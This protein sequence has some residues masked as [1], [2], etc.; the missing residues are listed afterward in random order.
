VCDIIVKYAEQIDANNIVELLKKYEIANIEVSYIKEKIIHFPYS[1][2]IAIDNN[3]II[4]TVFLTMDTL[5]SV[6]Y[7]LCVKE[8][9][10]RRNV[11]TLL[12]CKAEEECKKFGTNNIIGYIDHK[13]VA[14]R[15][16]TKKL[17]YEEYLHPFICVTKT[18]TKEK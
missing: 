5:I 1:I 3:E 15:T 9:Y 2:I 6:L 8:E 14:S 11:A 13:N 4:G 12:C 10:R 16:L 17:N 7:H 18:F